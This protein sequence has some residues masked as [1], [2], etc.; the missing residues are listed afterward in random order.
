[1]AQR[2]DVLFLTAT[3]F[4][5][6]LPVLNC[7]VFTAI[8][9]LKALVDV[10]LKLT[11]Y[12]SRYIADEEQRLN[13]IKSFYNPSQELPK[14]NFTNRNEVERYVGNPIY[15]YQML[16]RLVQF[17]SVEKLI[18]IDFT[19]G[20]V[21]NLERYKTIFPNEAD[22]KGAQAALMRL[23]QTYDLPPA[24]ISDGIAPDGPSVAKMS[25]DDTFA[26]GKAAYGSQDY[27]ESE[28]WMKETLRLLDIGRVQD[29]GPSRFEVLDFLAY[30]EHVLGKQEAAINHTV[31]MLRIDPS[32]ERIHSNLAIF[33][34]M[35]KESKADRKLMERYSKKTA[36]KKMKK[37][38]KFPKF[39][40]TPEE[41]H[42]QRYLLEKTVAKRLCRGETKPIA[43]ELKRKLLCWYKRSHPLL[44][45][46]PARIEKVHINPDIFLFRHVLNEKEVQRIK[47]LA[48]PVLN[49]ATV[50]NPSTGRI[51]YADY[52][53]SK[54]AWLDNGEDPLIQLIDKRVGAMSGLNMKSAES[55]QIANY[56]IGGH[57]DTHFDFSRLTPIRPPP[58]R[59]KNGTLTYRYGSGTKTST[60]IDKL[61]NRI[62]TFL[63]YLSDVEMG[64]GTVFTNIH[65]QIRPSMGDAAFWYNLNTDGTGDYDTR[66]A[67]CPVL[68]G[69]K[70]VANKWIHERGQEFIRPCPLRQYSN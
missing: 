60:I 55:L 37:E 68:L 27:Q 5:L 40:Y 45:L 59:R 13:R 16:R 53:I 61:G 8:S 9:H 12:L 56:G 67:A 46:K 44:V 17:S 63:I 28:L 18:Q 58:S 48:L 2:M 26:L 36:T 34:A 39:Y 25:A 6:N 3:L 70:W 51:E 31:E 24:V 35:V 19:R 11:N 7:E 23:Q 30:S 65:Q 41:D 62:A 66:H 49:R 4:L 43:R 57:Y 1:M 42:Y 69:E 14:M 22:F 20:L 52:R 29:E 64:G 47:E 38:R 15:G 33:R 10:E 21:Q 54:S 50:H 32:V